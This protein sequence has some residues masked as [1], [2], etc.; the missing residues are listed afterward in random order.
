[1]VEIPF[2][3]LT[4]LQKQFKKKEF[5]K[6]FYFFKLKQVKKDSQ[7]RAAPVAEGSIKIV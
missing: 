1:M 2:S 4:I 7:A 5:K 6:V 3:T